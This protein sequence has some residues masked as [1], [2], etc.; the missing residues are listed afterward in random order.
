MYALLYISLETTP[1]YDLIASLRVSNV[2]AEE[3]KKRYFVLYCPIALQCIT[4]LFSIAPAVLSLHHIRQG[5]ITPAY[6]L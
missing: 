2:G 3:N 1:R 4:M 6:C 5:F